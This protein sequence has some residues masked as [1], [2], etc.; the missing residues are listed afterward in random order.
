MDSA[1]ENN[2]PMIPPEFANHNI[3]TVNIT[4]MSAFTFARQYGGT[5]NAASTG[6]AASGGT[7]PPSRAINTQPQSLQGQQ[8]LPK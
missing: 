1:S 7:Q 2:E 4:P 5:T 6:G 8:D 3:V